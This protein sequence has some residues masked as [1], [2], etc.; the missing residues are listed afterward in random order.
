MGGA[1][2]WER[3]YRRGRWVCSSPSQ[4]PLHAER[5]A[6]VN[7]GSEDRQRIGGH[8]GSTGVLVPAC[9]GARQRKVGHAAENRKGEN[10]RVSAPR[11]PSESSAV[12]LLGLRGAL[13]LPGS[14]RVFRQPHCASPC[15]CNGLQRRDESNVTMLHPW[16]CYSIQL[17]RQHPL[18]MDDSLS[19][20]R[21]YCRTGVYQCYSTGLS[22]GLII[23]LCIFISVFIVDPLQWLWATGN[24]T[25]ELLRG[26]VGIVLGCWHWHCMP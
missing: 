11:L 24:A 20:A 9:R 6:T 10:A 23:F 2:Q 1:V 16:Y 19:A 15:P 4:E 5:L 12:I 26:T 8:T 25:D 13:P 18:L 7:E 22:F 14:V 17:V 21:A 3:A